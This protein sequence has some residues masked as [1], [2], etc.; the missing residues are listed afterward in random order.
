MSSMI[1]KALL[2]GNVFCQYQ[3]VVTVNNYKLFYYETLVRKRNKDGIIV[4]PLDFLHTIENKKMAAHLTQ[5]VFW[6]ATKH[7]SGNNEL[8]SINLSCIAIEDKSTSKMLESMIRNSNFADRIIFELEE[9][10]WL[11][12]QE[13]VQPYIY[14][15]KNL[16]VRFAVDDFGSGKI[17]YQT[18]DKMGIDIIKIDGML[19]KSCVDSGWGSMVVQSIAEYAYKNNL[20]TIAEEI[21]SKEALKNAYSYGVDMVQ[22]F[23]IQ[24][25][26]LWNQA[27]AISPSFVES[28]IY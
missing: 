23:Y 16:G 1:G 27:Q 9:A 20:I 14:Q 4:G 17:S 28:D 22:G 7:F 3:P 11:I 5:E 10:D 12:H 25:P 13:T 15:L 24:N 21:D 18:L 19:F 8:F 6:Q 2:E 26:L